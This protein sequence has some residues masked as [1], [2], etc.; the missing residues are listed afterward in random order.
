M[1]VLGALKD[2]ESP[3]RATALVPG[4][5]EHVECLTH[6]PGDVSLE[7]FVLREG[8]A[9]SKCAKRKGVTR[10]GDGP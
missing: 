2:R 1:P 10:M 6:E 7:K 5:H 3:N 9:F 8:H 4:E